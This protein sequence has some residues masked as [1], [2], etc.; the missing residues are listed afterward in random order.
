MPFLFM[1]IFS[2]TLLGHKTRAK[3][4]TIDVW[5]RGGKV[6]TTT[7]YQTVRSHNP[8][9]YK[10]ILNTVTSSNL[11]Q[12]LPLQVSALDGGEW[13]ASHSHSWRNYPNTNF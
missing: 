10:L 5:G 4:N 7:T 2:G 11:I 13:S 9:Y 12:M 6:H 3:Q 1:P 8:E